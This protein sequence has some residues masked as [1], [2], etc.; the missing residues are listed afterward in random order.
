LVKDKRMGTVLT[1]AKKRIRRFRNNSPRLKGLNKG[2]K[3]S[4]SSNLSAE[5]AGASPY[6]LSEFDRVKIPGSVV[7]TQNHLSKVPITR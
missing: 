6:L 4:C 7:L 5:L 2:G 1:V 3:Q